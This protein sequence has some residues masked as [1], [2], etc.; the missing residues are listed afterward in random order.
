MK[1]KT[2][3][4]GKKLFLGKTAIADLGMQRLEAIKGGARTIPFEPDSI[5]IT[6]CVDITSPGN[7]AVCQQYQCW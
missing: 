3:Q 1:K 7:G 4:L 5:Q 2:M 6:R